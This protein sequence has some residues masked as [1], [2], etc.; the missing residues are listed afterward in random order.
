MAKHITKEDKIKIVTLKEAGVKNLE[1]MNK[2]KISKATFFRIIQRYKLMNN[3]NRKKGSGRPKIFN[4][5]EIDIIKSK[6]KEN[7]KI[8]SRKLAKELN[9]VLDK[10]ATP[11]TY[12]NVLN[13]NDLAVYRPLKKP[14]LSIKNIS[15]RLM[16]AK[17]H[18]WDTIDYWKRILWS[19]ETKINLF[20]SDGMVY[21]RRPRGMRYDEKFL[22]PTIKHGGGNLMLWGCFSYNGVGKIE[23]V[24][25][26]MT[27]MSYT[28][29][30]NRN[31]LSSVK[32]LNM[33]DDFIFQ[34]DN[35]PKHKA[36]LTNDF[37]EKKE[38]EPLEWPS[39]SPDMNPIENLW[40]F[41][42]IKVNERRPKNMK[43]LEKI[44]EE[45]WYKIPKELCERLVCSLPKRVEELFK[46]KGR[47]TMY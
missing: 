32:K 38:I 11:R 45:E 40:Y 7:L 21:I 3:I 10:T 9:V 5:S 27:V 19:D 41:L 31:L 39:Q 35:D 24:K 26:N 28:Q 12:R 14:L 25:G 6:V 4:E 44:V 18:L 16:F 29:I 8:G 36:S 17:E 37:F 30:L 23:V 42:K 2:F 33:G 47:N 46:S 22:N 13:D 15:S 20:G 1:I 43:D 34:Q